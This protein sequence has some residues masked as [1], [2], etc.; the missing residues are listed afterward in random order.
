LDRGRQE[1]FAAKTTW[2]AIQK[3]E[4]ADREG[5]IWELVHETSRTLGCE[6]L[7]ISWH[8]AGR[9][10]PHPEGP[11][12]AE[13]CAGSLSGATATF[14]LSGGRDLVLVV[15]LHQAPESALAADIAFRFLQRLA[16]ATAERLER[17]R[18]SG[19]SGGG[20]RRPGRPAETPGPRDVAPADSR[21]APHVPPAPAVGLRTPDGEALGRPI[22]WWRRQEAAK[23]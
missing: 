3:I 11:P 14:R 16:L 12:P 21:R 19:R 5:R 10:A 23:P 15:A 8:R 9:P 4:L 1:R 17:L 22:S 6:V 18:T 7:R 2:D 13:A 20:R